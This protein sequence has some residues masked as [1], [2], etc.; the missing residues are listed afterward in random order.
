MLNSALILKYQ[1]GYVA[2][3]RFEDKSKD[4]NISSTDHEKLLDEV[5]EYINANNL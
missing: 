3:L 5:V 4:K 2:E 1:K